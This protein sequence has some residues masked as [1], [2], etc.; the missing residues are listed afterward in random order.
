MEEIETESE[1]LNAWDLSSP[2]EETAVEDSL[3]DVEEPE[4]ALDESDLAEITNTWDLSNPFEETAVEDS[5]WDV[6]EPELA[7]DE[8]DLAEVTNTWDLSNPLRK[9]SVE[10]SLWGV[11]EPELALDETDSEAMDAPTID[12]DLDA[13]STSPFNFD[14]ESDGDM[15]DLFE[16]EAFSSVE[17]S[18]NAAFNS[19]EDVDDLLGSQTTEAEALAVEGLDLPSLDESEAIPGLDN[20]FDAESGATDTSA[21]D[22]VPEFEEFSLFESS[23]ATD[24]SDPTALES[25]QASE[26]EALWSEQTLEDTDALDFL[27]VEPDA[28]N[29]EQELFGTEASSQ[30]WSFD[31]EEEVTVD[32]EAAMDWD[33]AEVPQAAEPTALESS[34]ASELEALWGEQTLEDTDALDFLAV[35]PDALNFEQELFG[36]E[37]SSQEWSFDLEEEATVDPEARWIG[38]RLSFPKPLSPRR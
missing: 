3:W 27:A 20:F 30:E 15:E 13:T 34:Q 11:E 35:E 24:K 31:L 5:L 6:E 16:N 37:A 29:L 9:R 21:S 19:L 4:L 26:L 25:S 10:E 17:E 18:Q 12:F 38:M 32:P 7:L 33:A 1:P 28:L 36:T 23:T 22:S 2:F 14:E 8:S